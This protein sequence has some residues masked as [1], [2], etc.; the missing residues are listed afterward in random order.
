MSWQRC[1]K[2]KA[3]SCCP[4]VFEPTS[5][6]KALRWL[7][8]LP[9]SDWPVLSYMAP[10]V[11]ELRSLQAHLTDLPLNESSAY[12]DIMLSW[13][14]DE[15]FRQRAEKTLPSWVLSEGVLQSALRLIPL[16]NCLFIKAGARGL[17]VV[18]RVNSKEF[19][20]WQKLEG[21]VG[22]VVTAAGSDG[23]LVIIYHEA[24][25]LEKTASVVGGGDSLLGGLLAGLSS[26][27]KTD[28]AGLDKLVL[29]GQR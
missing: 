15:M 10:N 12:S 7:N 17:L 24:I 14:T 4:A 25:K 28:P 9:A 18:Q 13:Q 29:I 16:V 3:D 19:G 8:A 6:I 23:G 20:D 11:H 26:G 5:N 22:T 1:N 27:L 2:Q 21:R